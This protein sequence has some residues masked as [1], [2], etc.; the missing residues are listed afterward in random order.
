MIEDPSLE[1]DLGMLRKKT[2]AHHTKKYFKNRNDFDDFIE[3]AYKFFLGERHKVTFYEGV[4]KA[5]EE[6]SSQY[7]LGVLTNGNADVN[8]LNIGHLFNFSISSMDVKSN[9]PNKY[10]F[11]RAREL[12]QINFENT[13]HVGDHPVNDVLGA[14]DLGI[15]TMWF[16]LNGVEWE[17]DDNPPIQFKQWSEFIDLMEK[18][19]GS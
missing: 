13:L 17:L 18:N 19:Y 5:L 16:N 7:K 10:H 1:Y 11:L 6:L 2:I 4:V 3:E 9:K 15:N 8:K 12:S 14:R